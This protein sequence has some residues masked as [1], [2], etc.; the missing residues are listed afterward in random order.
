MNIFSI[1]G[2][3]VYSLFML[4]VFIFIGYTIWYD[5]FHPDT[6]TT[7]EIEQQVKQEEDYGYR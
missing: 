5:I 6:R 2:W 7:G 3:V 4:V 1:I